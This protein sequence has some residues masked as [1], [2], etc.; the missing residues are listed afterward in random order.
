MDESGRTAEFCLKH[1]TLELVTRFGAPPNKTVTSRG[2]PYAVRLNA[3]T[4]SP[5]APSLC[6]RLIIS[7]P[8]FPA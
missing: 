8:A 5:A 2:R 3:K 1:R 7:S 6:A 4:F